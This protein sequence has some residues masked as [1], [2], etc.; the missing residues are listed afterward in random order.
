MNDVITFDTMT[1]V[2]LEGWW[3]DHRKKKNIKVVDQFFEDNNLFVKTA[4]GAVLPYS[5]IMN[6]VKTEKP[7]KIEETKPKQTNKPI[8]NLPKEILDEIETD[9][10]MLDDDAKLIAGLTTSNN[11]PETK[12]NLYHSGTNY[13]NSNILDKAFSKIPAPVSEYEIV[14]EGYS[15]IVK[16]LT[17]VMDIT[18]EE[19]TE[20]VTNKYF[21]DSKFNF[22]DKISRLM[23]PKD[24]DKDAEID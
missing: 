7:V 23:F 19:I 14:W 3:Y 24:V 13:S 16:M 5:S 22:K 1:G 20:Y 2:N 4:D 8:Y 18:E 15:E 11:I 21:S 6:C 12:K 10:V 9:D 17:E